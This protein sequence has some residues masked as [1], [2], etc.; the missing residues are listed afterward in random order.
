MEMGLTS[1]ALDLLIPL[2]VRECN[3]Q[4]NFVKRALLV[5]KALVTFFFFNLQC[6]FMIPDYHIYRALNFGLISKPLK[7][8]LLTLGEFI[9][10]EGGM[11]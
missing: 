6:G 7:I 5:Y 4:F 9:K 2:W 8:E 10:E 1:V 11:Q 3:Y